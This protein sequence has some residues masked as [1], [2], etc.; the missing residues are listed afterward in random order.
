[1]AS[2]SS[3][4]DEARLFLD[5][6]SD[7]IRHLAHSLVVGVDAITLHLVTVFSEEGVEVYHTQPIFLSHLLLDGDDTIDDD[8]VVDVPR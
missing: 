4:A 3:S 7:D 5:G 8:R 1:M 6:L 2:M